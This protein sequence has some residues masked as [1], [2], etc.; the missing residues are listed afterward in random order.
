[1]PHP[2]GSRGNRCSRGAVSGWVQLSGPAGFP[3]PLSFP[4]RKM[5][6]PPFDPENPQPPGR[7]R[8]TST[9]QAS[10]ITEM[11]TY[12]ATCTEH[13]AIYQIVFPIVYSEEK[14]SFGDTHTIMN[15]LRPA[16]FKDHIARFHE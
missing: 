11:E 4:R 16:L 9:V 3:N 8:I 14:N 12:T 13:G 7:F 10:M 6:P 5:L 2:N 1:M 15:T